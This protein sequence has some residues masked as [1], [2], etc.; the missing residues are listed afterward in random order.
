ML[1][2]STLPKTKSNFSFTFNLSS[3]NALNLDHSKILLFGKELTHHHMKVLHFDPLQIY[4]Y[5]KHCE[6][7]RNCLQTSNSSFSHNVF[8]PIPHLFFFLML[9]NPFPNNKFETRPNSKTLQTT[10]LSLTK[11]AESSSNG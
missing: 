7:R 6:K 5:G 9:F 3:A 2:I 8:Y 1:E 10:I 11:M 4:S